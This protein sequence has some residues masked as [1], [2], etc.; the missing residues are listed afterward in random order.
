MFDTIIL[1]TAAAERPIFT[2]VLSAH[3]PCLTIT[4]VETLA[5]LKALEPDRL[6]RAR[7]IAYAASVISSG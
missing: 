2:S 6:A 7:L 5:E 4:P 1:M 3:N